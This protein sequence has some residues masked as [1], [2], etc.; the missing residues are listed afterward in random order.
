MKIFHPLPFFLQGRL[1]R[2]SMS[3][4]LPSLTVPVILQNLCPSDKNG[5]SLGSVVTTLSRPL[6]VDKHW[7]ILP[8]NPI[9]RVYLFPSVPFLCSLPRLAL[10]PDP[11][12]LASYWSSYCAHRH[13]LAERGRRTYI[14]RSP[15]RPLHSRFLPVFESNVSPTTLTSTSTISTMSQHDSSVSSTTLAMPVV[16]DLFASY[17]DAQG[18]WIN[19]RSV[20]T[21]KNEEEAVSHPLSSSLLRVDI[22]RELR[23]AQYSRN[24]A[25]NEAKFARAQKSKRQD[26]PR[27]GHP[28]QR[29]KGAKRSG[30]RQPIARDLA[31]DSESDYEQHLSDSVFLERREAVLAPVRAS[32]DQP[33]STP[34]SP[35]LQPPTEKIPKG[36]TPPDAYTTATLPDSVLDIPTS[37]TV[38]EFRSYERHRHQAKKNARFT[39][40]KQ[41]KGTRVKPVRSRGSKSVKTENLR[42]P[43]H[44]DNCRRR[45]HL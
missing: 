13:D 19:E 37:D 8:I 5:S 36:Y 18:F 24:K 44:L 26:R 43:G 20:P 22:A 12:H 1:P 3:S 6:H 23:S 21:T 28:T 39:Q 17:S 31:A 9:Y 41:K 34:I 40:S 38:R 7:N 4:A 30:K 33:I 2:C 16:S 29:S 35:E 45:N 15:I 32:R 25:K 11:G 42:R 27:R 10:C 14:G